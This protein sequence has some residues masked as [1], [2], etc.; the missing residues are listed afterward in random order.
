MINSFPSNNLDLGRLRTVWSM[1]RSGHNS[2]GGAFLSDWRTSPRT[3]ASSVR[4]HWKL[5]KIRFQRNILGNQE[6][7]NYA[8]SHPWHS[9]FQSMSR[10]TRAP[11]WRTYLRRAS[12]HEA[13]GNV[14]HVA[15]LRKTHEPQVTLSLWRKGSYRVLS[16]RA[17]AQR[18]VI[19]KDFSG[20]KSTVDTQF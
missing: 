2:K 15:A 16:M 11:S 7:P 3:G 12:C 8:S 19:T 20:S 14:M 10:G 4:N 1:Q 17:A 9:S 18:P 6:C 5:L 13:P